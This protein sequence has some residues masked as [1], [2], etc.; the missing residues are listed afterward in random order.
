MQAI[1][2]GDLRAR[3]LAWLWGG[4]PFYIASAACIL[5]GLFQVLTPIYDKP[6]L[7][8]EKFFSLVSLQAYSLMLLGVTLLILQWKNVVDDAVAL[9]VLISL[10]VVGSAAGLDTIASGNP[11]PTLLFAFAGLV[12]ST[13]TVWGLH[14]RVVGRFAPLA[15]AGLGGL[16]LWSLAMPTL[17]G[18][19]IAAEALDP[20][21][22][23][24]WLAGWLAT[25]VAG[26][27]LVAEAWRT[28]AGLPREADAG[29]PF[30]RTAAMRWIV[31]G[32]ILAATIVHQ[33]SLAW[34]FGL[35]IRQSDLFAGVVLACAL[36]LEVLRAHRIH[37]ELQ[38][39]GVALVPLL[40]AMVIIP[41]GDLSFTVFAP[42]HTGDGSTPMAFWPGMV[43]VLN[44]LCHP[45]AV[46]LGFALYLASAAIH[47]KRPHLGYAAAAVGLLG[48]VTFGVHPLFMKGET[49]ELNLR[50]GVACVVAG[51][52]A[53]AAVRRGFRCRSSPASGSP[54]GRWRSP[55]SARSS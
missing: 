9:T 22:V 46:L 33:L 55:A 10:F 44:I 6:E 35:P 5:V 24:R 47:G 19:A 3:S 54:V 16:L 48:V 1:S 26:G 45:P 34:S 11:G 27:L 38:D 49:N 12:L 2:S 42:L 14:A 7:A 4:N 53:V 39:L 51:L 28:P 23:G 30:L 40:L 43:A 18:R 29:L 25:L 52:I 32:I 36:T 21:L 50:A 8:Y 41:S 15:L 37:G 13:T 20:D 17:L 31:A